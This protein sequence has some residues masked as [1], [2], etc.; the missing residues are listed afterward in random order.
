MIQSLL[1]QDDERRP[2]GSTAETLKAY[3]AAGRNRVEVDA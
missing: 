1:Y 3:V 2:L